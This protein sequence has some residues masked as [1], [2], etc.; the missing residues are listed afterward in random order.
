MAIDREVQ[1]QRRKAILE[2]LESEPMRRQI[3]LGGARR[4]RGYRV[5]QSTIGGALE[6]LGMGRGEGFSPPP[7]PQGS[8]NALGTMQQFIRR[9]RT[10]GPYMLV[11]DVNPGMAKAV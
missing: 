10:A 11:F 3:E 5:P 1:D 8:E 9:I 7:P 6:A 2:L 4:G